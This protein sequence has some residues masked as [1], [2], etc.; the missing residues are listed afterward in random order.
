MT[1]EPVQK[2]ICTMAIPTIISMLITSFYNMADTFFVAH[3]NKSATAAV[4]IVFSLMAIIQAIGFFFGHGSGNYISRELGRRNTDNAEK[5]ASV[6]FFTSFLCGLLLLILGMVFV[7]PV[8]KLLGATDTILPY[9]EQ[10]LRIIF[11]GAPFMT[12]SLTLNNQLRL[13]GNALFAMIGI[14]TGAVL[15]VGLDPLFIFGFNL[16]ISGAALATVISQIT[17][18]LILLICCYKSSAITIRFRNFKPSRS[19]YLSITQG[20]LPSLCRQ[21]LASVATILLNRAIGGYGDA[22]VAAMSIVLRI[23]NF[24]ASALLGFGQGFQPVCGFNYGAQLYGRVKKAFWF[25]VKFSTVT[26]AGLMAVGIIFAPQIVAAFCGNESEV[27]ELGITILRL[28]CIS[29]PFLGYVIMSN[30]MLQN[31][32]QYKEAAIVAIGRQGLFFI[33]ALLILPHYLGLLGIEIC[34][35]IADVMT[36]LLALPFGLKVL[37]RMKV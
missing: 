16:G 18:F 1:E 19:K 32:N 15:N 31:I 36:F 33:P 37:K 35:P 14:G 20:G 5:M 9:A 27:L 23:T 12:S 8:A 24:A 30:M 21:G 25:C 28:Q 26:L 4:G 10:Y 3:I 7:I 2:L 6:G 11:I 34:Q 22:A 13:Q 17:S 29:L